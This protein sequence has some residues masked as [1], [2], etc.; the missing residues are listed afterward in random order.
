LANEANPFS[1]APVDA[2]SDATSTSPVTI[3]DGSRSAVVLAPLVVAGRR[4]A[5]VGE[6]TLDRS[7]HTL[8]RSRLAEVQPELTA[9]AVADLPGAW[10]Q[11]TNR[12]AGSPLLRGLIGPQN[13]ITIE[14]L[15]FNN[16]TFRTGPNQYLATLD[17]SAIDRIELMLGP[18]GVM[19]GTDAMGGVID[20]GLPRLPA[21]GVRVPALSLW[22]QVAT[23]DEGKALGGQ[24]SW[25]G[26][27]WALEAG[28]ALRDHG[29]LQTGE[30]T[31]SR[32]SDYRQW[33]WHARAAALLPDRWV[34]QGTVMQNALDGAGR[35]DDLG[36]GNLRTSDNRDLFS[37]VE[38]RRS[39]GEGLLRELRI[40][41]VLHQMRE[42]NQSAR[43]TLKSGAVPS[44]DACAT[45]GKQVNADLPTSLP[46]EI[47]RQ[48]DNLDEVTTLGGLAS[49][50]LS[51]WQ[52]RARLS[53]GAEGWFDSVRSSAR[54]RDNKPTE[55]GAWAPLERGNYS[56]N[57]TYSQ[58]GGF[59]HLDATALELGDWQL[60]VN[61][62]VRGG[63]VSASAPGVPSIGDVQY[64]MPVLAATAGV[65]AQHSKTWAIF[66][67]ASNGLRAPNLQETT[68]LGNTGDQFEVPNADLRA[69]QVR[70]AELGVRVR[71]GAVQ[72]LVAGF[73]N[74][75]DDFIDREKVAASDYGKYGID[76]GDLGCPVLGD[77]KC[78]G[79]SRRINTGEAVI[80]G[81]EATVRTQLGYG[82][83][84]WVTGTWL[85]G[86]TTLNGVTQPLRR[87]TPLNGSVGVRWNHP[88]SGL[89]LEPWV[90]AASAQDR[91]NAGD[92]S[93]LRICE[94]PAKPGAALAG[95][96]CTGTPGW[97]TLNV[98]AGWRWDARLAALKS[99]R[100]DLDAGN[101][102]DV[103]YRV[104]GSGF[105]APGRGV[106]ATVT[107]GW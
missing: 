2:P 66:A 17:L 45:V 98:R 100:L 55:T 38:A 54:R 21:F 4:A 67:N 6:L 88:G 24:G 57:S 103:R 29:T 99:L 33:G 64:S 92:R 83:Q 42:A 49:A 31:T 58:I 84:P 46:G 72:A 11:T 12:G 90:R 10:G 7:V 61:G 3:T 89:Y 19:Y 36:K 81:A 76:A 56:D 82:V 20:L 96:T 25:A 52:D 22:T 102:L 80:Q 53:L 63:L 13:L 9:A 95:Q 68:V 70:A 75:F 104:H 39:V 34:L 69:E 30:G 43:C 5:A 48:F 23:V 73:Y 18:G 1:I 51:L 94:D 91:L 15:R 40:A 14:G 27:R 26:E 85:K 79:V 62:G 107:A 47:T 106:T 44:L 8:D 60:L 59:A 37:W 105:D 16:G 41:A 32:A 78:K 28:G 65:V 74:V 35:I 93:D 97:W 77:A 87:A 86:D 101:L 71:A 50:R